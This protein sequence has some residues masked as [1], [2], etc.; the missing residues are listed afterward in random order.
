MDGADT[1]IVSA[2]FATTTE[3]GLGTRILRRPL[4]EMRVQAD[5]T[6]VPSSASS[7]IAAEARAKGFE[8]CGLGE[9]GGS[10]REDE[11]DCDGRVCDRRRKDHVM[12]CLRESML[13]FWLM[14]GEGAWAKWCEGCYVGMRGPHWGVGRM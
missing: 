3:K 7:E 9:T 10:R 6:P 14:A 2:T 4:A 1:Y 13:A 5:A 8:G 12:Q 11:E